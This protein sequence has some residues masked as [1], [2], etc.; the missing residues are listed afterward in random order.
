M[1]P[2]NSPAAPSTQA[3]P[4]DKT[5]FTGKFNVNLEYSP[6]GTASFGPAGFTPQGVSATGTTDNKPS[7]FTA[8]QDKLGLKLDSQKAPGEILVID[9]A[10]KPS[11]N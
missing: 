9:H 2:T 6:D 5:G 4:N 7:I 1:N 8:L 11:E 10:E 3:P